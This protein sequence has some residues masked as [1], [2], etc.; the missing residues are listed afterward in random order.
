MSKRDLN[1]LL[2]RPTFNQKECSFMK[3]TNDHFNPKI[4]IFNELI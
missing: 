4:G 2:S 3:K 1:K